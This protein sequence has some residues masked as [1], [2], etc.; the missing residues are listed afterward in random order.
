[1]AHLPA[2]NAERKDIGSLGG[3]ILLHSEFFVE[4]HLRSLWTSFRCAYAS[5]GGICEICEP[6]ICQFDMT[7]LVD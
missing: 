4:I 6:E 3:Y 1:M 2:D 5:E 7:A